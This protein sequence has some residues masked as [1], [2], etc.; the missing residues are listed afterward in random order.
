MYRFLVHPLVE[1]AFR[2]AAIRSPKARRTLEGR[3]RWREQLAG[4][5]PRSPGVPRLHVHAASVGEFEAARP[6]IDALREREHPM[7]I[8]ASFFSSS[9]FAQQRGASG[10]DAACFL[11]TDSRGAMRAFM[12]TVDP[13]L[14]LVMRYDLWP[15]FVA[16]ARNHGA[17]VW[18]AC[19]VLRGDSV[20]FNPLLRGFFRRTYAGLGRIFAV[21][22]TDRAAFE[23]MSATPVEVAGDTRYDRVL[24]RAAAG[25]DLGALSASVIAGRT[26]LVAGSTWPH[27]EELL[28]SVAELPGLLP[29]IVPHEPSKAAV[30]DALARFPGARTLSDLER[31]ADAADVRAV[32]VDRT[33]LLAALYRAGHIAYVGGGFGEGV[34]SVLEPAAYGIPVLCGPRIERSRDASEMAALGAL[35]VVRERGDVLREVSRLLNDPAAREEAG[36]RAGRFVNERAGATR[37]IVTAIENELPG[38]RG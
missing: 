6:I 25:A 17:P 30:A 8:T 3:A 18:L 20:R 34:H 12:R 2:A 1:L 4:L 16:A 10:L 38:L 23:R 14:V 7:V 37:T 31:G 22:D 32:I 24:A 19:G 5:A 35:Q 36:A 11:P 26:V 15:E 28:R 21:T 29:A 9:G 33:G 27:D 13:D